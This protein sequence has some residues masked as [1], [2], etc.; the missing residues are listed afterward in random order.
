MGHYH[1]IYDIRLINLISKLFT[2]NQSF[3]SDELSGWIEQSQDLMLRSTASFL[4][5]TYSGPFLSYGFVIVIKV[6][7]NFF[8]IWIQFS[9]GAKKT[10]GCFGSKFYPIRMLA[11]SSFSFWWCITSFRQPSWSR[12]LAEVWV[13][14]PTKAS[15]FKSLS[16]SHKLQTLHCGGMLIYEPHFGG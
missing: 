2:N 5:V 15:C 1:T 9:D 10:K 14:I 13:P 16:A 4:I 12:L 11:W 7:H 3:T 6:P 8:P